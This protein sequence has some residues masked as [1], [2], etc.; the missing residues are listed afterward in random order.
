[1]KVS[2]VVK[3]LSKAHII[4]RLTNFKILNSSSKHKVVTL[5]MRYY[6]GMVVKKNIIHDKQRNT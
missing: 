4:E 2:N 1:V 6:K 3:F 5:K